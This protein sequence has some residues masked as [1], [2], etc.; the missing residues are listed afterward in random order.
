[1]GVPRDSLRFDHFPSLFYRQACF[2]PRGPTTHQRA[3][4]G[5]TCRSKL[6]RHPGACGFILSRTVEHYRRMVVE[7][8][9]LCSANG[10]FGRQPDRSHGN[11][12]VGKKTS[13]GSDIGQDHR[14]S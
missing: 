12:I 4:L 13:L 5:P 9:L 14:L 11:E 1:M 8:H 7:T 3:R 2:L 10:V 6:S